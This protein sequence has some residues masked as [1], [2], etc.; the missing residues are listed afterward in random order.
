MIYRYILVSFL[1]CFSGICLGEA[2]ESS[3]QDLETPSHAGNV[4]LKILDENKDA[5]GPALAREVVRTFLSDE[6]WSKE[7]VRIRKQFEVWKGENEGDIGKFLN[8]RFLAVA[9]AAVG[10]KTEK[11]QK[12]AIWLALYQEFKESPP[13]M[14]PRYLKSHRPSL[15]RVFKAFSWERAAQYVKG[16]EWR[17]DLP[18]RKPKKNIKER[19]PVE[20]D[21]E[22]MENEAP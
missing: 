5:A 15:E 20:K 21:P 12:A 4:L 19:G 8:S 3:G 7:V 6:D 13:V 9:L 16:K 11:M 17:Q 2:N 10:A 22:Q 18:V 1:L 14:V